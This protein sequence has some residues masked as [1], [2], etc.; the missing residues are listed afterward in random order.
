MASQ[1][2]PPGQDPAAGAA[3]ADS[4]LPQ[5]LANLPSWARPYAALSR[6]DRPVGIWLL[7]LPCWIGLALTSIAD[8]LGPMAIV[9]AW[10]FFVGAIP[11]RGA[12]CTWNDI[13][14]RDLDAQVARTADRPLPSGQVTLTQAYIWLA[15]Q[16]AI[17]FFVWLFLPL[18]GKI[19]ALLALPLVLAYPYMKR[20]TWWPQAFLGIVFNWGVVVAAAAIDQ[21]G[22]DTLLMWAGLACWTVA[23][24]TIYASQDAEDDALV[25]VRSTARL[26]AERTALGA[27]AFHLAAGGLIALAAIAAGAPQIGALTV[28][29]FLAHGAWQAI[30]LRD[31]RPQTALAVFKSN[32]WA[33]AIL[34]AGFT[35]ASLV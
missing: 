35:L 8:G 26:F 28:L 30:R 23:Y 19:I 16:L 14:D 12:G 1:T 2:D 4:A 18:D 34:L 22:L 32:V 13:R 29:V 9:W 24:D 11:M 31:L 3:P 21:V 15:V 10:L 5:W 25:G 27:F 33:G 20:V 17:G 7:A 6:L